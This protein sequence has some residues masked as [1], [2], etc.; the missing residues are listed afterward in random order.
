MSNVIPS[1]SVTISGTP[2]LV[3]SSPQVT[4]LPSNLPLVI[5]DID[6]TIVNV[7]N[8]RFMLVRND[9]IVPL[10]GA[11]ETLQ[12]VSKSHIVAYLTARPPW[13]ASKTVD[14]LKTHGFPPGLLL[15]KDTFPIFT[16]TR[17][18]KIRAVGL[19]KRRFVAI[20]WGIGNNENDCAA[21]MMHNIRCIVIAESPA[22]RQIQG[23]ISAKDWNEIG[24]II[25]SR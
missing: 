11:A 17:K 4:S 21:Y 25:S 8:V 20:R 15:F 19:L 9:K 7:S 23:A 10:A 5:S 12:Q 3:F 18:Y 6:Q 1:L 13:Q 16:S 24:K 2:S 22:R 14:W